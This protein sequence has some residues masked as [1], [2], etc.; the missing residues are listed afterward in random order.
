MKKSYNHGT[1][2]RV[3][4]KIFF[5]IWLFFGL[6][7]ACCRAELPFNTNYVPL[8]LLAYRLDVQLDPGTQ[9]LAGAATLTIRNDAQ[10]E[11]SNIPFTMFS[12]FEASPAENVKEYEL[13]G[14]LM[15][16][17]VLV[18][19]LPQ[20]L[21]P[22]QTAEA[23]IRFQTKPVA[24]PLSFFGFVP[25][26]VDENIVHLTTG[27]FPVPLSFPTPYGRIGLP[28]DAYLPDMNI[29]TQIRLTLP[30][31]APLAAIGDIMETEKHDGVATYR[32]ESPYFNL[33]FVAGRGY[34]VE[35]L[36][37]GG[38]EFQFA[39]LNE[40]KDKGLVFQ[41]KEMEETARL[42]KSYYD[43]FSSRFA[44]LPT[45]K[46]ILLNTATR[47]IFG[48]ETESPFIII[49]MPKLL[50]GW[51]R[52]H[53]YIV[54]HE[55]GHWWWGP[56][57]VKTFPD[58]PYHS[59]GVRNIDPYHIWLWESST[60]YFT[61]EAMAAANGTSWLQEFSHNNTMEDPPLGESA[62]KSIIS[63]PDDLKFDKGVWVWRALAWKMGGEKF[64]KLIHEIFAR[65]KSDY[66]TR[67]KFE[68]LVEEIEGETYDQ[69][70]VEWLFLSD[71]PDYVIS[72]V[73]EDESSNAWLVTVKNNGATHMPVPVAAFG[74]DGKAVQQQIV[75]LGPNEK[76]IVNF[77]LNSGIAGFEIDPEKHILQKSFG[78]DRFEMGK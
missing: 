10:E 61:F 51:Y 36:N 2:P 24:D 64:T 45:E 48:I 41:R 49:A 60:E 63:H 56:P 7:A 16:K 27:C 78:N 47:G 3:S 58:D 43:F 13:D 5:V 31:D 19:D 66:V 44:P 62:S 1:Y 46:I 35:S 68:A 52:Q 6:T 8:S 77:G 73:V 26:V 32:I 30:E 21:A 12:G 14:L 57:Y 53:F 39:Y 59:S 67:E 34:T 65:F 11:I 4:T 71:I 29:P 18:F 25:C 55:M 33:A 15:A 22:G 72:D 23:V 75:N 50:D 20:P 28:P 17:N 9:S 54:A 69:F 42:I 38:I 37:Y 70:F 76:V 74:K 40:W